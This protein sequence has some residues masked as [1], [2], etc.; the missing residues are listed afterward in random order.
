MNNH[1]SRFELVVKYC[2]KFTGLIPVNLVLMF[3]VG[4]VVS[5]FSQQFNSLPWLTRTSIS[6]TTYLP[7]R[8]EE[9]RMMRR[10]IVRYLC[11]SYVLTMTS[12]CRSVKKRFP[13]F[14]HLIDA[15]CYNVVYSLI[16]N[17]LLNKKARRILIMVFMCNNCKQ[18][19]VI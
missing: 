19:F 5:R 8:D 9:S 18:F 6:L 1:F 12:I 15:G 2:K 13:T 10:S 11:L 3:Y 7:G 16:M 4:Q 14:K 17:L